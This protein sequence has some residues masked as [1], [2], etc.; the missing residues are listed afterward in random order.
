MMRIA[1]YFFVSMLTI[2]LSFMS[3]ACEKKSR[4]QNV[5]H[6]SHNRNFQIQ[7]SENSDLII[8]LGH[9]LRIGGRPSKD[10]ITR[11]QAALKL[12]SEQEN[13]IFILSGKGAVEGFYEADVM[14]QWLQNRGISSD[15]II[16]E[17]QSMS[18]IENAVFTEKIIR[19]LSFKS[20]TLI[21]SASHIDRAE[22]IFLKILERTHTF[23]STSA[24]NIINDN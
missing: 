23:T 7:D 12:S 11:L 3:H 16:C 6:H 5:L 22:T 4:S 18:T 2:T 19:S 17:K 24:E 10:L 9:Q 14:S 1:T 15:T 21:T 8:V 13:P 20:I